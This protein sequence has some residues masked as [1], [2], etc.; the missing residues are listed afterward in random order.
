[1]PRDTFRA[2]VHNPYQDYEVEMNKIMLKNP[3]CS[4]T[5]VHE[6]GYRLYCFSEDDWCLEP[7]GRWRPKIPA[8]SAFVGPWQGAAQQRHVARQRNR[9]ADDAGR[10][11]AVLRPRADHRPA[12]RERADRC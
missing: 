7:Y 2:N 11:P 4:E 6:G 3:A 12:T 5:L 8:V 9:S 10:Q 1:M